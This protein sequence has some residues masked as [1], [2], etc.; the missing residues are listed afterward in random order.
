MKVEHWIDEKVEQWRNG[1]PETR[2]SV[3]WQSSGAVYQCTS[4]ECCILETWS[5]K[6]KERITGSTGASKQRSLENWSIRAMEQYNNGSVDPRSS[7]TVEQL[8]SGQ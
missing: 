4:K 6:P 5:N 8:S 1:A 2:E 3:E 7:C